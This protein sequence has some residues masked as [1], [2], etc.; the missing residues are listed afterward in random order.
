MPVLEHV[1]IPKTPL[2]L[3]E[4]QVRWTAINRHILDKRYTME[5]ALLPLARRIGTLIAYNIPHKPVQDELASYLTMLVMEVFEFGRK[6]AIREI[7]ALRSVSPQP[8]LTPP[9]T[10]A[11]AVR[12][13]PKNSVVALHILEDIGYWMDYQAYQEVREAKEAE[14]GGGHGGEEAGGHGGEGGGHGYEDVLAEHEVYE[15]ALHRL[16][17]DKTL[18]KITED[19]FRR[20]VLDLSAPPRS[21]SATRREVHRGQGSPER[22]SASL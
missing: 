14:E 18:G 20:S 6:E 13:R 7:A 3:A 19:Q 17:R 16:E 21:A 1:F 22:S 8:N 15:K 2:T 9:P 11:A 10:P 12:A 5:Q 4:E